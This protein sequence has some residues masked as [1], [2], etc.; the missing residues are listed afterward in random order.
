MKRNYYG[1]NIFPVADQAEA[2][3]GNGDEEPDHNHEDCDNEIEGGNNEI[4]DIE[5]PKE[6]S[7]DSVEAYP[8]KPILHIF[9]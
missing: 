6:K 3:N 1:L 4:E 2:T 5:E 9:K 8:H 7:V